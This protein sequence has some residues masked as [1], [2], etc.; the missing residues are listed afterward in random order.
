MIGAWWNAGRHMRAAALP[1]SL[2]DSRTVMWTPHV[3]T[4]PG[5]LEFEIDYRCQGLS[6]DIE[7]T[8]HPDWDPEMIASYPVQ[9]PTE[10]L[11]VDLSRGGALI[12]SGCRGC[13]WIRYLA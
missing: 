8:Y 2:L 1:Q 7:A 9:H 10:L 12:P 3:I 5:Q 13:G 4:T 11:I 6:D